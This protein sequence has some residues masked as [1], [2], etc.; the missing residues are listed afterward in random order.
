MIRN[1]VSRPETEVSIQRDENTWRSGAEKMIKHA[2][3]LEM[4][5]NML[6][7]SPSFWTFLQG[8]MQG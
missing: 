6:E 3:A 7:R 1:Q 5:T 4:E 8:L 2:L